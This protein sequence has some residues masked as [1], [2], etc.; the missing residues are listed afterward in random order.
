MAKKYSIL[1]RIVQAVPGLR[2][3]LAT[4][5]TL[6]P[7]PLSARAYAFLR[8]RVFKD[9]E[10]RVGAFYRAFDQ[11]KQAGANNPA[12]YFEFGVARGTSIISSY[13]IARENGLDLNIY[14]CD[15]F[16][17][18][19]SGEGEVFEAGDMA[20]S[21]RVF[22]RFIDKAGVPLER[23]T[24][25]PGFFNVSL[26]PALKQ[27]LGLKPGI[28]V[29][30]NDSDLYESTRDVLD[31]IEDLALPG[32]VIIFD[33]WHSFRAEKNPADFGEQKAFAE[34]RARPQWELLFETAEA[35]VAFVKKAVAS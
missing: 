33:D 7:K 34:W 28:A 13:T 19:P 22:R 23:V 16:E 8:R 5:F 15:S 18:L 35:N 31:W 4:A 26:T 9:N 1:K 6:L 2:E 14:A 25:I 17:G 27:T 21:D 30:H 10:P 20:Y 29:F 32:S 12:N 24:S 3:A 11:I